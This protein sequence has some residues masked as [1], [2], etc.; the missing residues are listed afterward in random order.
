MSLTNGQH[1]GIF[2]DT[3]TLAD[4]P[5]GQMYFLPAELKSQGRLLAAQ[6]LRPSILRSPAVRQTIEFV[7][8]L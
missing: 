7:L 1:L 6:I 2:M 5:P 3:E 4:L 8:P